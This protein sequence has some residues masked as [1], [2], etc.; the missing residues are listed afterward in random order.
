MDTNW[1][2]MR[3][4][5]APTSGNMF[6]RDGFYLHNS[7]KGFSHGCIE[8]GSTF[9][10]TDFFSSLLLRASELRSGSKLSLRVTYS[11]PEQSTLGRTKR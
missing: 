1:G 5:L 4:R 3:V 7:H 2:T 10:G 11:Y 6:K 9:E 8:V